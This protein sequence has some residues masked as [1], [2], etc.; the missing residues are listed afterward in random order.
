LCPA[1]TWEWNAAT[2]GNW[3]DSAN[4]LLNGAPAPAGQ[5]PG[6][7]LS[8]DDV[9]LFDKGAAAGATLNV[10]INP[11]LSLSFTGWRDQLTVATAVLEVS[12]QDARFALTDGSTIYLV[13][14]SSLKL[15]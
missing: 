11:L 2:A 12:G 14:N 9:V 1:G 15:P 4:W 13:A 3:S 10:A 5:Y 8:E 7:G 6:G